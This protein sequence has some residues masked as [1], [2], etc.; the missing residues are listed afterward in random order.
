MDALQI[1]VPTTVCNVKR[2]NELETVYD[3]TVEEAHEFFAN[4]L[5]T[6]NCMDAMRYASSSILVSGK[7]RVC[8]IVGGSTPKPATGTKGKC[9]RVVSTI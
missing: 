2:T 9:R 7:G 6:L 3:L 1:C 4:G 8:E 5:L